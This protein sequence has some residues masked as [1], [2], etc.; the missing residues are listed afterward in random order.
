MGWLRNILARVRAFVIEHTNLLRYLPVV[1]IIL[2][3][4]YLGWKGVS[5]SSIQLLSLAEIAVIA[6]AAYIA[7]VEVHRNQEWRRRE[8]SQDLLYYITFGELK[9]LRDEV[10]EQYEIEFWN[11]DQNF[12]DVASKLPDQERENFRFKVKRLLNCFEVMAIGIKNGVL[13]DEICYDS[14]WP[15][16]VGYT[17]WAEPL[18][19]DVRDKTWLSIY[20]DLENLVHGD[21]GWAERAA[22]D[23]DRAREILT[24]RP[25]LTRAPKP[26]P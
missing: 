21:G 10:E 3:A 19:Q 20:R 15:V 23:E 11:P 24:E 2:G 9:Q 12:E 7:I 17:R 6:S 18:L 22:K 8:A 4:L 5:E 16:V 1:L 14:V 13:D 25:D 26:Q